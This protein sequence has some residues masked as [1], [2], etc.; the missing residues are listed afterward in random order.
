M[1]TKLIASAIAALFAQFALAGEWVQMFDG[2]TLNGWK[3]NTENPSTF[4]VEDGTIK[5]VG[6]LVVAL[7]D[8]I[9]GVC[10]I[11]IHALFYPLVI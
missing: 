1:K 7:L 2:K 6:V 3:V 5:V 10:C 8:L 11:L 4:S 9:N